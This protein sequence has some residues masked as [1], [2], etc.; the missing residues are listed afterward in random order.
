MCPDIRAQPQTSFCRVH[1]DW[2]TESEPLDTLTLN[3]DLARHLLNAMV[4]S[5]LIRLEQLALL[6]VGIAVVV[7]LTTWLLYTLLM[8][9]G[10]AGFHLALAAW[11]LIGHQM[12]NPPVAVSVSGATFGHPQRLGTAFT[13]R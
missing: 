7:G 13:I 1:A 5:G 8:W 10:T 2:T 4:D 3:V 6:R 11:P 9:V 12:P